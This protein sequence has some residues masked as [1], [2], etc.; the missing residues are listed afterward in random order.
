[1][2]VNSLT[3]GRWFNSQRKETVP[4]YIIKGSAV[5][6]T[7]PVKITMMTAAEK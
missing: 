4:V 1:V 3:R 2:V 6:R 7:G 5:L